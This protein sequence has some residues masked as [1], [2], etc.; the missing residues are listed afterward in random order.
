M[1]TARELEALK[2]I[3]VLKHK[4]WIHYKDPKTSFVY[5]GIVTSLNPVTVAPNVKV[6]IKVADQYGDQVTKTVLAEDVV[7]STLCHVPTKF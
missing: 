6:R 7:I 2:A 3:P 4:M 5:Q 1:R